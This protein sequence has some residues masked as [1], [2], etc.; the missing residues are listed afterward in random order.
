MLRQVLNRSTLGENLSDEELAHLEEQYPYEVVHVQKGDIILHS[1]ETLKHLILIAKGSLH[2]EMI[3]DTG[4]V[5]LVEVLDT[6][7]VAAPAIL[8]SSSRK[9]PVTLSAGTD[10]ILLKISKPVFLEMLHT[11]STLMKN[12][13]QMVCDIGVFLT[14]R[15]HQLTLMSL[16]KKVSEYLLALSDQQGEGDVVHVRKPWQEIASRFG[17]SRQSLART[18]SQMEDDGFISIDGKKITLLKPD[19]MLW[20]D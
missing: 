13:L 2:A 7:R 4:K 12:Y 17:V 9:M 10:S 5:L 8:L 20:L 1:G 3:A 15:I 18:L 14:N 6:G 19:Q 11:S 16:Q